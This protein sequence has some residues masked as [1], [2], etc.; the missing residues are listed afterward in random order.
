MRRF[1]DLDLERSWEGYYSYCA[2]FH[3][4]M[5]KK[6]SQ[7]HVTQRSTLPSLLGVPADLL[8]LQTSS[9]PTSR[10]SVLCAFYVFER[11]RTELGR[12]RHF[13]GAF[14]V[15]YT[16]LFLAEQCILGVYV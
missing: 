9:S 1:S 15:W 14:R 4:P 5:Q 3:R 13:L 11:E 6:T 12:R 10:C 16:V 8:A 7:Q 2:Y